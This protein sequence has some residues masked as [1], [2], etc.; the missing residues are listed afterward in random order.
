MFTIANFLLAIALIPLV[1][2]T[3]LPSRAA[4]IHVG[5]TGAENYSSIWHAIY[6]AD[7]GDIV[8]L[9]RGTY[10]EIVNINKRV[11]LI[12]EDRSSTII[13]EHTDVSD[14]MVCISADSVRIAN[15]TLRNSSYLSNG[16]TLSSVRD[17]TL[18]NI[19]FERT[20]IVIAGDKIEHWNTHH[21]DISN[22]MDDKPIYYWKNVT[23]GTVPPGAGEVIL[24]NTKY[25]SVQHQEFS[26]STT[27]IEIGFSTFNTIAE[28]VL[29]LTRDDSIH[30]FESDNNTIVDNEIVTGEISIHLQSSDGNFVIDNHGSCW[31]C[32]WLESSH[33]DILVRNRFSSGPAQSAFWGVFIENSNHTMMADNELTRAGVLVQGSMFEHWNTHVLAANNTI[34]GKPLYYWRNVNGGAVPVN[35]GEVI[36]A[37]VTNIAVEGQNMGDGSRGIQVAYSK[38]VSIS[39]NILSDGYGRLIK[40]YR[41]SRSEIAN[42]TITDSRYWYGIDL[43]S[44]DNN[45]I[46]DN[47]VSNNPG[48]GLE[49]S[50]DNAIANNTV[51]A[52]S[53]SSSDYNA[54]VRNTATYGGLDLQQS[55][56]N[57][58]RD[59]A[60]SQASL[61]KSHGNTIYHN[62]LFEQ[63]G[64]PARDS[65]GTN[66]WDNGYPSGG[67]YWAS[68]HFNDSMSGPGQ[69][70]Q[71][72]DGIVDQPMLITGGSSMDRYPLMQVRGPPP[73]R[74]LAPRMLNCT[75][76]VFSVTLSWE[77]PFHNGTSPVI[78]YRIYRAVEYRERELI[79]EVGNVRTYT[80][81]NVVQGTFYHYS[82]SAVNSQGEGP[83]TN[84]VRVT[85]PV[86]TGPNGSADE[87]LRQAL[88]LAGA[89]LT[90]GIVP[91]IAIVLFLRSR[92]RKGKKP[93]PESQPET[94]DNQSSQP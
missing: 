63:D 91:I 55:D 8:Y 44:S 6:D 89:A 77:A 49:D 28:N 19:S 76:T 87:N 56:E 85:I 7:P 94:Q 71:G 65:E 78:G 51:Y 21:I 53:I 66:A 61:Y 2:L 14:C 57:I 27:S 73:W 75:P 16:L 34:N 36:L 69:N 58:I 54:I 42:N 5:G 12:G 68:G 41:S 46:M 9:H 64:I 67:N 22:T 10:N 82:V 80:D 81:V 90:A 52:M 47:V 17:I 3:P 18:E 32:L 70:Q 93:E 35:A 50:R 26:E 37:N 83:P 15:L 25:V 62:D 11:S 92:R 86:I 13:Q 74:P 60:L 45:T 23:G 40:L 31:M 72:S 79:A 20:S 4:V 30:L 29:N 1:T 24:A 88:I 38:G 43:E 84:E 39:N 48:I 33:N 59:N